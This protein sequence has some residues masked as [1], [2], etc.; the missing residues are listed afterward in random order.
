MTGRR[1]R[2]AIVYTLLLPLPLLLV[3]LSV[4]A[5]THDISGLMSAFAARGGWLYWPLAMVWPWLAVFASLLR[6]SGREQRDA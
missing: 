2:F 4:A 6:K 5:V 1:L 3:L